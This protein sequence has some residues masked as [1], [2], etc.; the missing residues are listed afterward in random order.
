MKSNTIRI[1][2][3]RT[4]PGAGGGARDTASQRAVLTIANV[5]LLPFI[6]RSFD[7]CTL[8]KVTTLAIDFFSFHK[9]KIPN[10]STF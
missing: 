7:I 1:F 2:I 5:F 3:L 8:E 10:P 4:A 9:P 6:P